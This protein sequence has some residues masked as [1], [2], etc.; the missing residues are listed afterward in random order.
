MSHFSRISNKA[1]P[2]RCSFA[3]AHAL[4]ALLSA[5]IYSKLSLLNMKFLAFICARGGSVGFKNKNITP[6]CGKPL[7]MVYRTSLAIQIY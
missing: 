4:D 2:A 6:I 7:I 5:D 1:I 3:D